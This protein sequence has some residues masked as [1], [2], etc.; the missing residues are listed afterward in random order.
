MLEPAGGGALDTAD[1]DHVLEQVG[2]GQG[3]GGFGDGGSGGAKAAAVGGADDGM[4]V[5]GRA[6]GSAPAVVAVVRA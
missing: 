6:V 4:G 5:V 1:G 3:F 2:F